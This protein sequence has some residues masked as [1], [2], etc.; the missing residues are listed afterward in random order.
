MFKK[1]QKGQSM[2]EVIITISILIGVILGL[3][4]LSTSVFFLSQ[5][6]VNETQAAYLVQEGFEALR[7]IRD[8]NW[9]DIAV[10]NENTDYYLLYDSETKIWSLTTTPNDIDGYERKIRINN[11]L[12][13]DINVN[14]QIDA[15]DP[16]N[17]NGVLIDTDTKK[18]IITVNWMDRSNAS[19][20]YSATSYLTNWH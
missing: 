11:A 18:I 16:I 13:E 1:K 3:V 20:N 5:K 9:D 7:K 15:E 12:R 8:S 6:S 2:L 17:P 4:V 10:L 19:R 14:G